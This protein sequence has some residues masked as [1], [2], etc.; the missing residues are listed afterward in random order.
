MHTKTNTKTSPGWGFEREDEMNTDRFKF[1][2]FIKS[3]RMLV[4]LKWFCIED[5][6]TVSLMTV[7]GRPM[8][9]KRDDVILE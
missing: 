5:D 9:L 2:A 1:R 8:N 6:G 3:Q 4:Y 7:D